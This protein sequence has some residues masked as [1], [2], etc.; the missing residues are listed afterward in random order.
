MRIYPARLATLVLLAAAFVFTTAARCSADQT[1]PDD[2][3]VQVTVDENAK[4]VHV[5]IDGQPFTAYLY[6]GEPLK[7][8]VL[9]PI[10]TADGQKVTRGYPIDPQPGERTDHPHHLGMWLNYG[11][12]NGLDFWN[13]SDAIPAENA[14]RYGTILHR[15]INAVE[16]GDVGVLEVTMEWVDAA[17]SPLLRE[18]TRFEF[19]GDGHTRMIDRTTTLTA[20]ESRVDM[21]DNKEGMIAVR[22]A[23]AL[24]LPEERPTQV[25]GPDG[26]PVRVPSIEGITGNY[27]NSEGVTGGD[28]WGKRATWCMLTGTLDEK[29]VSLVLIDHPENVGYPTYWHARGYGLFSANPLGQAALSDGAETLNFGLEPG[30]STTFRYRLVVA[31]GSELTPAEAEAMREAFAANAE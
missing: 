9:H 30:A 15:E 24:E 21:T 4:T 17:G 28:V 25:V 23:R 5:T 3:K 13:N 14:D 11:D 1:G 29:P 22:V 12:V 6:V 7:K 18:N 20:L 31:S 16:S 27:V 2:E 26:N 8:P 10:I 19:R